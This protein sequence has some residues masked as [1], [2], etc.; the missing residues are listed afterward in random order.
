MALTGTRVATML[1]AAVSFIPVGAVA[2]ATAV[3]LQPVLDGL[4]APAFLTH[5]HDA[6]NRLFIVEQPGRI[7]TLSSGETSPTLFLDITSRVRFGGERGLLGL[8]F[9]PNFESN[10]RFF[11]NYTRDPDGATVIA[12]YRVSATSPNVAGAEET[13][14]LTVDQPFGNHNGGMIAFGPDGF[15]YIGMGDGG[16]ANDPGNRAQDM[17]EL[18]GKILRIDVDR[19][20]SETIP[21]SIPESNPFVGA[22]A[23]RGEIYA[24]GLRNP[25]RFSFDRS[26]GALF[27]GDVGQ[28]SVEEIDV[29]ISGGN[30]GWRVF[31]GARC[32]G[33]GPVACV[34]SN[35]VGPVAEYSNTGQAG[36]CSVTGGYVYRGIR[37]SLPEG[38]YVYG[39]FCSGEIFM[40]RD[41][42]VSVL[43]DTTLGLASFG[44]DES[45]E[46]YVVD[47]GGAIHRIINPDASTLSFDIGDRGSVSSVTPGAGDGLQVGYGRLRADGVGIVPAGVAIFSFKPNGVVVS[48]AGVQATVPTLSGRFYAE[49]GGAVNTGVAIANPNVQDATVSFFFTGSDGTNFGNGTLSVPANGQI[50]RFLDEPPFDV[51]PDRATS[52][53]FISSHRVGVVALRG[54]TNER[55]EF[56]VTTLP[57]SALSSPVGQTLVMP[58]FADGGGWATQIILVNPTDETLTGSLTFFGQGT[59]STPAEEVSLSVGGQTG[60]TFPFAIN[61]RSTQRF[62]TSGD[63]GMIL[64]GSVTVAAD[65][66]SP[67]P[68]G[69]GIFSF[70]Q[71]GITVSEASVPASGN[72]SIFRVWVEGAGDFG[73]GEPGSIQSGMALRN[74][75]GV[76]STVELELLDANGN[77]TGFSGS[78]TLAGN[79]QVSAFVNQFEGFR[80]LPF[81]FR[82][83]LRITGSTALSVVGLRGR[84]N[85]RGEF[86]ITTILPV[87][88]NSAASTAERIFPHFADGMDYTTQFIL[89]SGSAGAMGRGAL[90]L[91]SQSGESAGVNLP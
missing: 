22:S 49:V 59:A 29:I 87:D 7:Q 23:A 64:T 4:S 17:N 43:L 39:D 70:R 24:V 56:L 12:Q 5:A 40:F 86:L 45:G 41:G 26:T 80:S 57:V 48:E 91:F 20:A 77:P 11:V 28:N 62:R 66:G 2:E 88:E 75:E 89:F 33:L 6:T 78:V 67:T 54:V 71:N 58:H 10:R 32:T 8:A 73:A 79:G 3:E 50:A 37:G 42:A 63:G 21:Y 61:P 83:V 36:R 13:V 38:A 65:P 69:F 51:E 25:W 76:P 1:I 60:G 15:L 74:G 31:E 34:E 27:A 44:E 55:S 14:L 81:P 9:H 16:S 30:F 52:F 72:A 18:L 35:F 46:I 47:I 90:T 68:S 82:G 19:P 53:T 84:Y 85:A